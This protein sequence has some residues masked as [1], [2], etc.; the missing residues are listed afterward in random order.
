LRSDG[1]EVIRLEA[2]SLSRD[3]ARAEANEDAFVVLPGR[4]YAV[5]D[6]VSDRTG[7]RYDGE[8]SG[9]HAARLVAATLER[10]LLGPAPPVEMIVP[11][12]TA[13]LHEA[14]LRHGTLAAAQ[15]SWGNRL[16]CTLALALLDGPR[17]HLVLVG[18]SGIRLDGRQVLQMDKDLDYITATLRSHA[19]HRVADPDPAVRDRVA[20]QVSW[21]GLG[22]DSSVFAPDFSR[23][24][25]AAIGDA[26]EAE[27]VAALPHVPRAD[28][29]H[30]L[31]RGIVG[32][33]GDYQ[34]TADSVLGYACLDGFAVPRSLMQVSTIEARGVETVELF[35]DGYFDVGAEA[36]LASWEARHAEVELEDP[37]KVGRFRSTKGSVPG[38]WSDDRTY[39]GVR[40]R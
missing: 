39:V 8:L 22:Q 37:A 3:P 35:T 29:V 27:L 10:L 14:Y 32:G 33:Q 19:W 31:N 17:L 28:I 34:N 38:R 6:G 15:E 30:L 18:D 1:G 23:A 36:T 21:K 26:A 13:A 9:R 25:I 16:C 7:T 40:L 5:I 4:A 11:T 12:L 24:D 2:S 20:R